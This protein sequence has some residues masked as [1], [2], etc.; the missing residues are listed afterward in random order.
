MNLLVFGTGMIV[1][2]FLDGID[3]MPFDKVFLCGRNKDNVDVLVEKFNLA[4]AYY[5]VEEAL[6]SETEVAYVGLPNNLHFEYAKK[7]LEAGKHVIVEK[8]F[9][10]NLKEAKA[11]WD[12]AKANNKMI[13][14]ASLVFY[15]PAYKSLEK[16]LRSLG[17]IHVVECN[18]SQY[19]SRYDRFLKGDIAPALNIENCGG[20]LMDINVYN[21]N[22]MIGLFGMPKSI[23]YEAT[24]LHSIDVS[25]VAYL[26]YGDLK[27]SCIASKST[28]AP[29]HICIQGDK[30]SI[31]LPSSMSRAYKYE[32]TFNNG[33]VKD[34][35]FEDTHHRMYHEFSEFVRCIMQ[36]DHESCEQYI[37]RSF[38]CLEVLDACR[39][40][41]VIVFSSDK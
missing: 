2:D 36:V 20:A 37:N 28:H 5:D 30:A 38:S 26:D 4:G 12:V 10:T 23:S 14:E 25:G 19:S 13:F 7:S 22:L 31:H 6:S 17:N 24:I 27:A 8:P 29:R 35:N 39:K 41:A 9:M 3:E 34:R 40:D 15:F 21:V 11:I 32:I 16:D 18:F 33:D 1:N